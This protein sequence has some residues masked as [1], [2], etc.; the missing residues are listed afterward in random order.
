MAGTAGSKYGII[1]D[2]LP[3]R[4]DAKIVA[5]KKRLKNLRRILKNKRSA[6]NKT[7]NQI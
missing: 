3:L 1:N 6:R 2:G 4:S 7:N 5:S